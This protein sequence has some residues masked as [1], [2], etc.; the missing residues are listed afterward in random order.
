TW[1]SRKFEKYAAEVFHSL[2]A[3]V[4]DETLQPEERIAAAR[5]LVSYRILDK[6]VVQALLDCITPGAAPELAAGLLRALE[7]SE[8]PE[9]GLLM[10]DRRP[11]LTPSTRAAGLGV[12]L[13]RSEWTRA[14]LDRAHKGDVKLAE[15]SLDQRQALAE[16]PDRSLRRRAQALL[17]RGGALPSP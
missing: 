8:G 3:R 10:L 2:L 4:K 15:L 1:G 7:V 17:N 6:E 13:S 16:H 5:E 9:A 14:L 12:L 11:G